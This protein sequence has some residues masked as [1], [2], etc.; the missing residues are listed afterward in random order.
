[1]KMSPALAL[2]AVLGLA[3]CGGG[4][5]DAATNEAPATDEAPAAVAPKSET[6]VA[7]ATAFDLSK[8]PVST[9]ELGAFPYVGVPQGYEVRDDSTMDLAAFPIWTGAG[10]QIVEGKVYMARSGT[11]DEKT[12]S[13]LEFER[14]LQKAVEAAGGV[15]VASSEPTSEA[16][17][18]IPETI[19]QDMRLGMGPM[20]GNPFTSYVIRRADRTIWLQVVSDSHNS[21][22]AVVEAPAQ[23]TPQ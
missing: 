1:M 19:R 14:G 22:W 6:P 20:Y 15:R 4:S 13:R 16:I 8:I 18:E 21:A 17:D 10:F 5:E 11:P 7:Q 9:A 12:Y 2:C 23:T 3:A